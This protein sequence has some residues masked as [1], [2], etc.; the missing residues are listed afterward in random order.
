MREFIH[1]IGGRHV[2]YAVLF[3]ATLVILWTLERRSRSNAS[4]FRFDDLLT[5]D[6]KTSKAACVMFGAFALS[7]WIL[8]FLTINEKITE[9]YFGAY[10]AAW[11]GPAVAKIIKG[12]DA[13]STSTVTATSTTVEK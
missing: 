9:G 5:E 4:A 1:D 2:M 6:G 12:P 11:V 3:C 8:I 10:L 13:V 7:T